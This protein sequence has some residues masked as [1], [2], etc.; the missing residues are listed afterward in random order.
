MFKA[1]WSIFKSVNVLKSKSF[2]FGVSDVMPK[3]K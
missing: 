3:N 2:E 1:F